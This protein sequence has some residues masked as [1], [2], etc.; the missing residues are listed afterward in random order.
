MQLHK[1]VCVSFEKMDNADLFKHHT[2]ICKQVLHLDHVK[3]FDANCSLCAIYYISH[4]RA[5]KATI[6]EAP[7]D[8]SCGFFHRCVIP[9]FVEK[10]D[11]VM[12]MF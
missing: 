10:E 9:V 11:V 5:L 12:S 3:R 1:P 7:S 6:T 2:Y 8:N 4:L